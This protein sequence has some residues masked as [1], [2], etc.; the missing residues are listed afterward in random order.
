MSNLDRLVKLLEPRSGF[1]DPAHEARDIASAD[2]PASRGG[3]SANPGTPAG[4]YPER[5]TL[6]NP[7][8]A[9]MRIRIMTSVRSVSNLHGDGFSSFNLMPVAVIRQPRYLRTIPGNN[10]P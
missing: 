4:T 7:W 3:G 8:G 10:F 2:H 1:D 5:M 9:D 6:G